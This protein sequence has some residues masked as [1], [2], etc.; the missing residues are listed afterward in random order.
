MKNVRNLLCAVLAL[1]TLG[2]LGG[3]G[4][5]NGPRDNYTSTWWKNHS[6]GRC[7][8]VALPVK[9]RTPCALS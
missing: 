1:G 8:S 5:T 9:R 4:A 6:V 2:A 3:C 7:V